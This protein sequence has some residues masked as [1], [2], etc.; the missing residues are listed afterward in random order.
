MMAF[1]HRDKLFAHA[2]A[3]VST[4]VRTVCGLTGGTGRPGRVDFR[5]R[6]DATIA[7]RD[8]RAAKELTGSFG[9]WFAHPY[10]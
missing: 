4:L 3:I 6:C 10:L 2:Y 9:T 1:R 7:I 5:A 8:Y